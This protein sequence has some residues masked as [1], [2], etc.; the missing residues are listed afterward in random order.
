MKYSFLDKKKKNSEVTF[1]AAE[2]IGG[3]ES[4]Q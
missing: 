1:M 2:H 4:Q 3:F